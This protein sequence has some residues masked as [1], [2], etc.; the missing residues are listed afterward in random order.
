MNSRTKQR[1][2]RNKGYIEEDENYSDENEENVSEKRQMEE[3][4]K[5]CVSPG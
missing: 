3:D 4:V 1:Q 5:C 2:T